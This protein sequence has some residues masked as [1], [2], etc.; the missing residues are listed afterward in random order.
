MR[1]PGRQAAAPSI[2]ALAAHRVAIEAVEP[3]IDAG[4][5]PAKGVAG[6]PVTVTADAFT[7]GHE[8]M[9]ASLL[10]WPLGEKEATEVEMTHVVNDR[11]QARFTPP[12]NRMYVYTVLAWRDD[13]GTW[14]KDTQKKI[15]AGQDVAIEAEE[16]R[17][18]IAAAA[19]ARPAPSREDKAALKALADAAGV[20]DTQ[21][22]L[23]VLLAPETLALMNRAG[24]RTN[25]TR[26]A[27]DL[28]LWADREAAAFSAWYEMFP[29]SQGQG[30][31]HGTF[32]DVIG[33]LPY[34]RD[35]GFDVLY[36]TPIHPIGSTNRKGKNNTLTP[37]PDDVG[38]PYAIGSAEGGQSA[39]HPQ[40]GTIEGFDALVGAADEHGLEIALDIALNASP[41]HPWIK[42]HPD[43]FEWRPD[44]S[45]KYAENPPKKYEDIVNYRYY[46]D[47]GSANAP[48]WEAIRDMFLFWAGHGV[49]TFRVDNPHTKP[50]PFWEFI[51]SE[52]QARHPGAIFLSEA[53]T[54]PKV[55]KRLAKLGFNQSYSYFTWRNEKWELE[56]Y[57]TE[58]TT[59][60]CRHYMRPNF[61]TSTPDINPVF[62]QTSGRPGFRI[63]AALA[64]T[65]SGNWGVYNGFEIC[66]AAPLPGKEEFLD[67]EKYEIKDWDFDAPGHVKDDLRLLN[68]LRRENPCM[69]DFTNLKFFDAGSEQVLYYGRF[70]PESD[71]YLLFHVLLDPHNPAEFGFEVPLWEFGLPDEASIEVQDAIQGNYF[72]WHGKEHRL[73]LDPETRPYAIWRLLPP[74]GARG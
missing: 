35:L 12:E 17:R 1:R 20:E 47:D 21:A 13:F 61:F 40:L 67:S 42:Q 43:W 23:D 71:S 22:R 26:Y 51:I 28:Q 3:E 15:A 30:L 69:R 45:I 65:L 50:Y 64:A 18:Q 14:H 73:T 58:L 6:Q 41:D 57:L 37:G 52:V 33:K 36:F 27:R 48:F 7:D 74:G 56:E 34:V 70:D 44:G 68:A 9:R 39:V 5:F 10:W 4:R 60:E 25:L 53:F 38:S 8:L 54:R 29:R 59:E 66:D 72:T 31:E 32:R 19:A 55:M 2:A 24:P 16:G 46:L 63:R 11:W 62:L 49:L